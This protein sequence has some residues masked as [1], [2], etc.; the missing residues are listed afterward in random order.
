MKWCLNL[1]SILVIS[2]P[3]FAQTPAVADGGVLNSSTFVK[4]QAV[5]QGSLVSIFGTELAASI[6]QA[7]SIPLSTSIAGVSVTFNN[8][9]APLLFVSTAQINAQLPWNTLAAGA[10]SGTA[11]VIVTRNGVASAAKPVTIGPA[12]PGVYAVNNLAIAINPDGTLAQPAGSIP[13]IAT[14]PAKGGDY[15]IMLGSGLGA[16]DSALAN[17]TNSRDKLRNVVVPPQV[18]VNGMTSQVLFAGISPDFVG[19]YQVNAIV[20]GV[21]GTGNSMPL[22]WQVSGLSS[23]ATTTIA[24]N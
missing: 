10:T 1:L 7:D 18:M 3:V 11:N 13:G 4:G 19:V 5:A 12:S 2:A 8:I 21:A 15:V 16:L 24:V 9:P 22:Q 14:R 6:A 23:P 20:P 17:G